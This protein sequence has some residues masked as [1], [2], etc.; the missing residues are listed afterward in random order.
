MYFKEEIKMKIRFLKSAMA[1]GL[2]LA[3]L[4]G[5]VTP[6]FASNNKQD[7]TEV[8]LRIDTSDIV[9]GSSDRTIDVNSA[10][11]SKY[12]VTKEEGKAINME[13]SQ[14]QA[15]V[16]PRFTITV[17]PE[18]GFRFKSD[19]VK[20]AAYYVLE[21][22][23]GEKATFVKA[24]GASNTLTLTVKLNK[25]VG[26]TS[27]LGVSDLEWDDNLTARWSQ[28]ESAQSY[29][30]RFYK[31]NVQ[32]REV[33]T[34]DTSYSFANDINTKG[35]YKFKVRANAYGKHGEWDISDEIEVDSEMLKR[36]GNGSNS[37]SNDKGSGNGS[38]MKDS[39]GWWYALPDRS[40]PV[41]AWKLINSKWY[42]FDNRGYM[43]TGWIEWKNLWYY[44][45]KTNGDMWVNSTTPD[46]Y[47]VNGDG[48]WVK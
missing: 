43:K 7:I 23:A 46:G 6:A 47:R 17:K 30:V 38:W 21:T 37:G 35:N 39:T 26:D 34:T 1:F 32:Q 9:I 44:L 2:S 3:L 31:G 11:D 15:G 27:Q 48:V 29:T 28:A 18:E 4:V 10:D 33:T 19:K 25:L 16:A 20:T 36:K 13:G 40:Y 42:F 5:V 24:S 12:T 22:T 45:D 8:K 14:W 41:N